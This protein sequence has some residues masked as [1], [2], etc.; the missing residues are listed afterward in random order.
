MC[1]QTPVVYGLEREK[2]GTGNTLPI[3][4]FVYSCICIVQWRIMEYLQCRAM[5]HNI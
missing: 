5:L 1:V 2:D 4:V 3:L